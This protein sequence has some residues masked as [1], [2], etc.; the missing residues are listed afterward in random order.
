MTYTIVD[1]TVYVNLCTSSYT[2][3]YA[4]EFVNSVKA[5]SH[6]RYQDAFHR[7]GY[8]YVA[9]RDLNDFFKKLECYGEFWQLEVAAV[10]RNYP[11]VAEH[12][13]NLDLMKKEAKTG[14]E[15]LEW[16]ETRAALVK[17]ERETN[18]LAVA[19]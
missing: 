19:S 10:F 5:T 1:G 2:D 3:E 13:K 11:S 14:P 18:G 12:A 15:A 17:T 7:N 9:P 6:K 16:I 4:D 8:I